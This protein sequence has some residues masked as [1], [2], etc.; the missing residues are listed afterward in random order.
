[1]CSIRK[2][3]S[4]TWLT[5]ARRVLKLTLNEAGRLKESVPFTGSAGTA[6]MRPN[7]SPK[8]TPLH[9]AA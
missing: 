5:E 8:P 7:S 1:M 4:Y 2:V 6:R 9:G 3:K